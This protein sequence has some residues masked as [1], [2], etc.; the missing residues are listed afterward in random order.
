MSDYT[1]RFGYDTIR[2]NWDMGSDVTVFPMPSEYEWYGDKPLPS[3][4]PPDPLQSSLQ[5]KC[6]EVLPFGGGKR[7]LKNGDI[8]LWRRQDGVFFE[9]RRGSHINMLSLETSLPK[10]LWGHNKYPVSVDL[11]PDA[12]EELTRVGRSFIPSL[13]PCSELDVWRIDATCDLRLQS[14]LEVALVGRALSDSTLH[15]VMPVRYPTGGSVAWPAYAGRPGA[16]CYGK[17]VESGDDTIAGL[18]RSEVQVMGGKQCRKALAF[19]VECGDLSPTLVSGRGKRCF[20]GETLAT[21][22][23]V[24]TGLLG[25]LN[26]LLDNAIDLV[27]GVNDMTAFEAIDLLEQKA[28]CS[29]SRAVQLV[30]YA[31]I[32][33]V[34]GWGMTGLDRKGVWMAKKSFEVAGVDAA[35][36]E[37]SAAEKVGAGLG[38]VAGGAVLGA[39]AGVGVALGDAL[40]EAI[41]SRRSSGEDAPSC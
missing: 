30:G 26:G 35:S 6:L 3:V 37:F 20:K 28:S 23:A 25:A 13:P 14:E 41:T 40:V 16:R 33:R 32:V 12:F 4:R 34:L 7:N 17:S 10:L 5:L 38:L 8:G 18:Y 15:G 19:A 9:W 36:I 27:R 22:R 39:A 2:L 31:H 11:L 24:C 29:R 1:R 21:E